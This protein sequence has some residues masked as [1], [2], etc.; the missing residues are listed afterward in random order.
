MV[1]ACPE[2]ATTQNMEEWTHHICGTLVTVTEDSDSENEDIV[3]ISL[4]YP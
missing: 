1:H 4:I 3:M 2:V